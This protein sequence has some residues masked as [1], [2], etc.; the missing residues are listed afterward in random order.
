MKKRI[1]VV[2]SSHASP[3]EN[4]KFSNHIDD[5]I[6]VSHGTHCYKNFNQYSLPQI[7]NKAIHELSQYQPLDEVIYVFCHNDIIFKTKDWGKKLLKH[8]NRGKLDK[9]HDIIGVAG[10]T[11]LPE[12]GR[13]WE[14]P[15][16]M[17]GIVEH[18]NG[19]REWV[20]EYSKPH[21]GVKNT[22]LVDGLFLAFDPDTII[23]KFD[24]NY[25][26]FHFYDVVWCFKNFLDGCNVGVVTDIRILHKSVGITN[27]Q[28][29]ENRIQFANEYKDDLPY[30]L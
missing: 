14:K 29:E 12:S 11:Y 18:T 21:F 25:K 15:Q 4:L 23:H 9:R 7:Y 17:V 8:F 13:W 16:R 22:V 5:T 10:T 28:W 26:G 24:E 6:G 20:S 30:T 2:F 19:L 3:E 1:E 27:Q